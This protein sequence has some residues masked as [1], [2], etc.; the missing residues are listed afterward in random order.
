[1]AWAS[2]KAI[3]TTNIDDLIPKI[4]SESNKYYVNDVLLRGP[5]ISGGSAIDYIP[6]QA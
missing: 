5:V 4:F 3:F 6:L 2:V 1:M